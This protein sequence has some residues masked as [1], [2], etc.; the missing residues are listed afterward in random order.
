MLSRQA[1]TRD[2]VCR[3]VG[4]HPVAVGTPSEYFGV[5]EGVDVANTTLNRTAASHHG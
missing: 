3:Q 4:T 5:V 2:A 1:G